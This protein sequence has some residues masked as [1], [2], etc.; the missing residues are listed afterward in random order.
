MA[1]PTSD[2]LALAARL[3]G[4]GFVDW[5][6]SIKNATYG[7]PKGRSTVASLRFFPIGRCTS[8]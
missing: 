7:K 3:L 4:D 2:A 6:R 1:Q 5:V 8:K